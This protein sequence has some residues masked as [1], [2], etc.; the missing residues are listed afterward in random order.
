MLRKLFAGKR[1][2]HLATRHSGAAPD[3]PWRENQ[4]T[5]VL[6]LAH[7]IPPGGELGE[8]AG[9]FI[10]LVVCTQEYWLEGAPEEGWSHPENDK[11]L[12]LK[13]SFPHL[14]FD[15]FSPQYYFD[16]EGLVEVVLEVDEIGIAAVEVAVRLFCLVNQVRGCYLNGKH[17]YPAEED[18]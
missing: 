3:R 6:L 2:L 9:W 14:S 16:P 8:D 15:E 13:E 5:E 10:P 18:Q 7:P 4:W 1:C 11:I 17:V 12:A